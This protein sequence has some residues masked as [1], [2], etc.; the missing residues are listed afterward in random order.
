MLLYPRLRTQPP[1]NSYFL[2]TS[3]L[4]EDTFTARIYKVS[5]NKL[6]K[7][8]GWL[9]IRAE[10]PSRLPSPYFL[11][12]RVSSPSHHYHFSLFATHCEASFTFDAPIKVPSFPLTFILASSDV[13][14]SFPP[15][16]CI[17][18]S[19]VS[20]SLPLSIAIPSL[21][22]ALQTPTRN[23]HV[24]PSNIPTLSQVFQF[25]LFLALLPRLNFNISYSPFD[26]LSPFKTLS[27][28]CP[29]ASNFWQLSPTI[30]LFQLNTNNIFY[31][32]ESK[33]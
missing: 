17:S 4:T 19:E 2:F 16:C 11:S 28:C 7:G 14:T 5:P 10:V 3:T 26:P 15:I 24:S 33:G 18:L 27:H 6:R 25:P 9:Q 20:Q 22:S 21:L 23:F 12:R 13:V 30:S 31:H 29:C 32:G 1:Q 8:C